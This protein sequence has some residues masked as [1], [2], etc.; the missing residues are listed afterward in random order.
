VSAHQHAENWIK[1]R[2]E[3]FNDSV[4]CPA[5]CPN[6]KVGHLVEYTFLI[7]LTTGDSNQDHSNFAWQWL[8][9]KLSGL[10]GGF[11]RGDNI[12]G[13]WTDSAGTVVIDVS[14]LYRVAIAQSDLGLLKVLM[15]QCKQQFYQESIYLAKTSDSVCLL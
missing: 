6:G 12:V 14:R 5:T 8:E 3:L 1:E 10:F 15:E 4:A 13:T 9:D 2:V 7:P 11:S